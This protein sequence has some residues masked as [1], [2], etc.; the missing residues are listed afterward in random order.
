MLGK[1]SDNTANEEKIRRLRERKFLT[2]ENQVNIMIVKGKAEDFFA[3]IP[4]PD[5]RLKD[6]FADIALE[7]AVNEAK[8]YPLQMQD[9]VISQGVSS[10]IGS[11]AAI[12]T[13]DILYKDGLFKPLTESERVTFNLLMFSDVLPAD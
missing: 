1:I 9:L 7:Y 10:F 11:T 6:K 8:N 2:Q 3:K 13:M 5:S 4:E 12:M